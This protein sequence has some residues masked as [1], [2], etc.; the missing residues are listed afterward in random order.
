[1]LLNCCEVSLWFTLWYQIN[2]PLSK[3]FIFWSKCTLTQSYSAIT[4]SCLWSQHDKSKCGEHRVSR[5]W[6][7]RAAACRD[8]FPV[9]ACTGFWTWCLYSEE[10][11]WNEP[12]QMTQR[13][14]PKLWFAPQESQ[15]NPHQGFY[16]W[17]LQESSA[18]IEA[19]WIILKEVCTFSD[20]AFKWSHVH[21]S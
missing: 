10:Q 9:L 15:W 18:L 6:T 2:L 11:S 8:R 5:G 7:A 21:S 16:T 17:P 3:A 20:F 1:M 19:T 4:W 13:D 14:C 12:G